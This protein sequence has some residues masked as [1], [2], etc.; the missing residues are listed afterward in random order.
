MTHRELRNSSG[1]ILRAV[2]AGESIRVTDNDRLAALIVPPPSDPV[3]DLIE[4]GQARP[5]VRQPG[6]FAAMERTRSTMSTKEI[7]DT[8]DSLDVSDRLVSSWLLHTGL[9]CGS[10]QRQEVTVDTVIG[11]LKTVTQ[12]DLLRVDLVNAPR[13]A[14]GLR[15]QDALHLAVAVRT[16]ADT[17]VTYDQ[18]QAAAAP[19]LGMRVLQPR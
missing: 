16:G 12:V 9:H 3:E 4:K 6:G 10:H 17:I 19:S 1:E 11:V 5:G 13:Q 2:A 8:L 18:E 15:S 7:I 14:A